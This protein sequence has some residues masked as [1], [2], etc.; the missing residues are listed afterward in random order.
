MSEASRFEVGGTAGR[1]LHK[2]TFVGVASL[3]AHLGSGYPGRASDEAG[4]VGDP[5]SFAHLKRTEYVETVDRG[6]FGVGLA[7]GGRVRR[8]GRRVRLPLTLS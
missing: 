4:I 2:E 6:N 7:C 1:E 5:Q 3:C 8:G